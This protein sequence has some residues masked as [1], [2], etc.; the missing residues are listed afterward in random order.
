MQSILIYV[1][2]VQVP[3]DY[4]MTEGESITLEQNHSCNVLSLPW[5]MTCFCSVVLIVWKRIL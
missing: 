1:Q 3:V 4:I 2:M 5:S